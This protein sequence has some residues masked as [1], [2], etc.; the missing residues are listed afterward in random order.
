MGGKLLEGGAVVDLNDCDREPIHIPG[1]IQPFGVLFALDEEMT[2]TQVS[3][4]V[5]DHL[6]LRV[7]EVLGRPLSESVDPAGAEEVRSVLREQRWLDANPL[8]IGACGKRFDGI[9]H[10]HEGASILELE[11]N[12]E[13]A[14][15]RSIHHPFRAAL[16]RV[17]RA[18]SLSELATVIT[19]E[20]RHTTGFERV[21][22]Y[23][24]HEDGSGSV[25]AEAKD[26]AHEPYLGL[27]YPASDIPAQARRLYLKSWLRLIFDVDQKAARIVPAL[28]PDTGAPLDLSFSVLRSVSPIHIEYM[29][30]MGVR[31]S[32]SISLIVR[33]RLWG[34]ISCLNH[35]GP[36]RVSQ[37]TRSACEFMGRL[38][39]LQ[40][41]AFEDR[42]LLALRASRRATE[43][44]LYRAMKEATG[45]VL[46]ALIAQPR[47]LM[48]LVEAG[49]A[50]VVE[51]GEPVTCGGA[52]PV[53]VIREIAR[54]LEE[55]G[56]LR[57]FASDSLGV[58]FPPALAASDVASG[59]LTF[60][61]PGARLMWFRPEIIQ[62]VNWGGDPTKPVD[63][64]AGQRLRPR[65]SF[66]L[67]KE[68]VRA[69]SRPWT[70]SDL[71][72]ADELQRRATEVDIERRLSS[73]Q[74]A[75]RVRDEVLAVVSH[76]LRNPLSVILLEAVQLLGHL[77]ETGDPHA[78][79]LRQSVER[80]RRSTTRMK[81]LIQDLLE[82]ARIE[83]KTFPLEIRPVESRVLLEDAVT[84]A[85]PLADAKHISLVLDLHD[86]PK[87]DADPHRIS[88]VLSNLLSNAIK[89]TP[90]DG[91]V[92]LRAWPRDGALAVAIADTGRGIAQE[93]L[94]HVFDRFWRPQ[95]SKGEGTG[96]G[97][98]IARGVVEAHGG[99]VWAE[100]SPQ[101]ATFTFTLPLEPR[102]D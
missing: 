45:S 25:D 16:L 8:G 44:V 3:E 98:Y 13:T 62:T 82:L 79:E 9:V 65:H 75:V 18:S 27:R 87:I 41:A 72:A 64:E 61:L 73:E 57:P 101:G 74:H 55:K 34:L 83:A 54:W 38:A 80:I 42:E 90:E 58:D 30:N 100:S 46:A 60:A 51:N 70:P 56:D 5:T 28:R 43:N 48:N 15:E 50:A 67:W 99:R 93:D 6:S 17:Q 14:E 68:D 36:R 94:T 97:L 49:G 26:A 10:R 4:N 47:A 22:F 39:S 63:A 24:F 32:M 12:P 40:I 91:T 86:P 96:L 7:D 2:V 81:A 71:E 92:T 29:K 1:T 19:Q 21:M 31:A 78:R 59:L 53:D 23:R 52:P 33:D 69:R 89:F 76:D 11:P 20:M 35:T 77:P 85:Q 88:Q 95:G 84:D 37:R 102:R 66:A